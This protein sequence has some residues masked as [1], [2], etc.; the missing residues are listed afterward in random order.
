MLDFILIKYKIKSFIQ[1]YHILDSDRDIIKCKC[2]N[3]ISPFGREINKF[4]DSKQHRLNI[5]YSEN[6]IELINNF[7]NYINEFDDFKEYDLVS[8]IIRNNKYG[9][10]IRFHLKTNNNNTTTIFKHI[11]KDNIEIANWIDYQIDKKINIDFHP[12]CLWIDEKNKKY[13]IS[14]IIDTV[15]Q[16]KS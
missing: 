13:G 14:F 2:C 9:D 15:Y 3:V 6:L 7:E 10:I 16:K 4:K 8:N 5:K 11:N 1:K 12:D